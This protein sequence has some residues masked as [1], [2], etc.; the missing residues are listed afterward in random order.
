MCFCLVGPGQR[1]S[2]KGAKHKF[3]C[4]ALPPPNQLSDR[5]NFTT[6]RR[7][8]LKRANARHT[9]A[10]WAGA[11]PLPEIILTSPMM[12]EVPSRRAMSII[13]LHF[14]KSLNFMRFETLF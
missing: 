11:A 9:R 5:N 14:T 3:K 6:T 4:I 12:F 7:I 1:R 10:P 13:T 8:N 2:P